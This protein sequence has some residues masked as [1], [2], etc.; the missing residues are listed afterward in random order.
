MSILKKLFHPLYQMNKKIIGIWGACLALFIGCSSNIDEPVNND[1]TTEQGIKEFS[2]LALGDSYTIGQGVELSES[3]PFQLKD[4]L[5]NTKRKI[6]KL[7]V[8]AKT[9]WTTRDLLQAIEQEAPSS[10][11]LVSLLIGVNNQF[12]NRKFSEFQEEFTL[13]LNIAISL[14]GNKDK[15]IVISIPDYGVTPF[16]SLSGNPST[17]SNEI[18][19]YNMYIEQQCVERNITFIDVTSISREFGNL[20]LGLASDSL[21]PSGFQYGKW[22]EK[23]FPEADKLLQNKLRAIKPALLH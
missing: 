15:V 5:Q 2:F 18:D 1:I 7:T 22:I 9:G 11:D 3:W 4:S 16:G 19:A 14:A 17:I 13:L 21:H 23:I 12:Q 8:I 10:H 6:D 20:S